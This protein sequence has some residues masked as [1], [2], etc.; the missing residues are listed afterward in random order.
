[1]GK[2][3]QGSSGWQGMKYAGG[4]VWRP[5]IPARDNRKMMITV[6]FLQIYAFFFLHCPS[7][8]PIK[9]VYRIL[10]FA[11]L[12]AIFRQS[13]P[14]KLKL[15]FTVHTKITSTVL[16]LQDI[17]HVFLKSMQCLK[18]KRL[19]FFLIMHEPAFFFLNYI[20]IWPH[21]CCFEQTKEQ[22]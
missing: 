6:H 3:D 5:Y 11:S 1:M 16:P 2:H 14:K 12:Y 20:C 7:Q 22:K 19:Y 10:N 17:C 18:R 15:G 4:A 13:L 21:Q 9:N 8:M